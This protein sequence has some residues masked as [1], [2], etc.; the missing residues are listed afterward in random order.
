MDWQREHPGELYPPPPHIAALI[1]MTDDE[2][3]DWE[4]RR[5]E[6]LALAQKPL[7]F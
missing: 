1:D 7:E 3:A 5:A 6:V 4:A 2:R